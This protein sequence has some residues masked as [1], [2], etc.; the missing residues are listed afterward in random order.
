MEHS[1]EFN[2]AE[3]ISNTFKNNQKIIK[4]YLENASGYHHDN[5]D[6]AL[7]YFNYLSKLL[8][9]PKELTKVQNSYLKFFQDQQAIWKN[10]FTPSNSLDKTLSTPVEKADRRFSAIEWSEY[11]YFNFIKQSYLLLEKLSEQIIDETEIDEKKKKKLGFYNEQYMDLFSPANFLA[12]N[13]E[14][15]KHAIDTN[16]KSLWD[17][18]NNLTNDVE[19]GRISQVDESLFE[20]GKNLA[21]TPGNIV[22]ENE[23]IQLIQ[24]SPSTKKV[25]EIPL[26]IIPP[27]INKFYIL[28]IDPKKS[29]VKFLVE[30]GITVYIISWRNP[31]P[32][33]GNVTFDDYVKEGALKAIEVARTISNVKQINTLGYCLGG[34]LLGVA[35]AI[36]S[37]DKKSNPI[38]SATFLASMIDFSDIGPMGDVID[39]A[40]VKKLERGEMLNGGIMHGHDMERAFNLIRASDLIWNYAVNNYLLGLSPTA[41]DVMYW[42]NDNTNL[43]AKMY[44]YYMRYMILENKLSRKNS[45]TICKTPIDI[46]KIEFPVFVV[47]L[48]EDYIS[49]AKTAFLT[50]KL[51]SGQVEFILGGSG[52]VIGTI[53]PP[54]KN[55][56]G[57]YLDGKLGDSFEEWRNTAKYHEGSWWTP[58]TERLINNSGKQIPAP[59]K[60]GNE[61]YKIIE[62]APG[63][64][65]KE[66]CHLIFKNNNYA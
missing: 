17:G 3:Y 10:I 15:L 54:S 22:F 50:T 34:T 59:E 57:Y 2:I 64:Y 44:T 18:F 23:L 51:V 43:P 26:L 52:H 28:D 19:K 61:K 30:Q 6:I 47:G 56:Y 9:S 41:F 14:A 66:K 45:L 5:R 12:T 58:W 20:V 1:K 39:E 31:I 48:S 53:N 11:P 21:M 62:P 37:V 38:N 35:S 7:T 60:A 27:W 65:V 25:H 46:S 8:I 32:G 36:V 16:G 24:Y 42:T 29:F 13:P 55:K 40:L 49:P 4:N 63:R 33:M